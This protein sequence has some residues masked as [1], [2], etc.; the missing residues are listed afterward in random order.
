MMNDECLKLRRVSLFI[1]PHSS[2]IFP[3]QC[4]LFINNPA[5][6]MIARK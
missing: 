6:S 3:S 5:E 2:F 1:I 4:R